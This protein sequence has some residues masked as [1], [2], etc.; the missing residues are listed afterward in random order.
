M[1]KLQN[2]VWREKESLLLVT[3]L[4]QPAQKENTH[5]HRPPA[6]MVTI[7]SH[8]WNSFIALNLIKNI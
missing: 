1:R 8:Q 3:F 4:R 6:T 5:T 7:A 2:T